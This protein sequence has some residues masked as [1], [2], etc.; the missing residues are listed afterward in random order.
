[1]AAPKRL[2]TFQY[3]SIVTVS[4]MSFVGEVLAAAVSSRSRQ[5]VCQTRLYQLK[6]DDEI[7]AGTLWVRECHEPYHPSLRK[8]WT[9]ASIFRS[10]AEGYRVGAHT[11]PG[12]VILSPGG[13][14]D[15]VVSLRMAH[16]IHSG[17]ASPSASR[18]ILSLLQTDEVMRS[19]AKRG[20][21]KRDLFSYATYSR[22]WSRA[23][24]DTICAMWTEKAN[25]DRR[26]VVDGC[27]QCG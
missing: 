27:R 3:G 20:R 24:A 6:T 17:H 21:H 25:T 8:Q 13:N 2:E 23:H 11:E 15:G 26:D 10:I 5:A 7:V 16:G 1:M 22:T 12:H 14:V 18:R 19:K 9:D 4:V